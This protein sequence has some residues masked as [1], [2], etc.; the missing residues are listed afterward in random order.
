MPGCLAEETQ[1]R[2]QASRTALI[3]CVALRPQRPGWLVTLL[4]IL[5]PIFYFLAMGAT[6]NP[7][8]V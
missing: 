8:L 3:I 4:M 1:R 7:C 5:A 6:I 2:P